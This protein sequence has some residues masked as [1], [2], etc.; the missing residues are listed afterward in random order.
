MVRRKNLILGHLLDAKREHMGPEVK[1]HEQFSQNQDINEATHGSF[2]ED[3]NI[4]IQSRK[5][6]H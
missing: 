6:G 3:G 2:V 4:I 5:R 1:T